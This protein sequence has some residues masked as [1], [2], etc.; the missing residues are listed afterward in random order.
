MIRQHNPLHSEPARN[1]KA[2]QCGACRRLGDGSPLR[3][4]S[5]KAFTI[6]GTLIEYTVHSSGERRAMNGTTDARMPAGR[7]IEYLDAMRGLAAVY[8]VLFHL[9][10]VG[11]VPV[12]GWFKGFAVEGASGVMLFFVISCFSLL[13]TMPARLKE[14]SPTI[15]FYLHRLFR[16]VPL[17]YLWLILSCIRNPVLHG[18]HN[19]PME[20]ANNF[21]MIF[22]LIP[23]QQSGIAM[24]SWTIG[25]EVLFYA[26]FPLIYFSV[27][28]LSHATIFI[29]TSFAAYL[30]MLVV[31]DHLPLSASDVGQYK[32]WL[33]T[34]DIPVFAF[35]AICY[36]IIFSE[37]F[38]GIQPKK[39]AGS[40]LI[41]SCALIFVMRS[42]GIITDKLF[43]GNPYMWHGLA[44]ALLL[45]GIALFP[46]KVIVNRA[47][48]FL[49][50]ISYSIYLSHGTVILL[51]KPIYQWIGQFIK[52]DT[53]FYFSCLGITIL[54]VLPLS[55]ATYKLV[56]EPFIRFGKKAHNKL[57][58]P[59]AAQA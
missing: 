1:A 46:I 56:E 37:R 9:I 47:T 55:Y 49:G 22:N 50:K 40:V 30:G 35:G 29:V 25:V 52:N 57:M 44:Y 23:G 41:A 26:I 45:L 48:S 39:L 42:N 53:A 38:Q 51:S 59:A 7:R 4:L 19:T 27:R 6:P 31:I 11:S 12:P 34:K 18:I 3:L 24:A 36:F 43:A 5:R 2:P 28:N 10:F 17:F 21:L 13:Y 16:I 14:S 20:I 33:F 15:S 8:V 32:F 58:S 54:M